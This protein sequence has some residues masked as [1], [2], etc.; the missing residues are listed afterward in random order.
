MF[1]G[2][3]AAAA[4]LVTVVPESPVA[5]AAVGVAW[6]DLVWPILVLAGKEK[7]SVDRGDP[8]QRSIGFDSY[9]YSHSLLLSNL[10]ALLPAVA[11]ALIFQSALAGIV[12]WLASISH[13]LLDIVVHLPDLP[14]AGFGPHD[15]KIGA[16]L[17]KLPKSA[18]VME[19]LFFA[20]AILATA[21]PSAWTG[22]LGGGLLLHL[23]NANSFFGFT[24]SNP[25]GTP[26]RFATL[27]LV[28]YLGATVW[29][30]S[31]WR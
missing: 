3:Y 9:P 17:W 28:G 12:F 22:L 23:L 8:L 1:V 26:T 6:P 19:F 16:G 13:W 4:I 18:F 29:F 30:I 15:Q 11:V 2:H 5:A 21:H 25:F 27:T 31:A 7:V 14:V 24:K 20:V 10:L